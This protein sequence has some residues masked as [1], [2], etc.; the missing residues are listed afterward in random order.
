[1]PIYKQK[2][3]IDF[4]EILLKLILSGKNKARESADK[5]VQIS[6][7]LEIIRLTCNQKDTPVSVSLEFTSKLRLMFASMQGTR[8]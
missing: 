8:R 4:I 1:M 5:N 2:Y 3:I 6:K 7:N